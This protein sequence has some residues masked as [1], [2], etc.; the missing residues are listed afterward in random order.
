MS[1]ARDFD[2]SGGSPPA[3]PVSGISRMET[4]DPEGSFF[5]FH[6]AMKE[7]SIY[8]VYTANNDN[9]PRENRVK[10]AAQVLLGSF[11]I[12]VH[13]KEQP[14]LPLIATYYTHVADKLL[15]W[16]RS[17]DQLSIALDILDDELEDME[18]IT[19]IKPAKDAYAARKVTNKNC[20]IMK[21]VTLAMQ[22]WVVDQMG[23][24]ARDAI[25]T[26]HMEDCVAK[27]SP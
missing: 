27:A 4:K 26:S 24:E 17:D 25:I 5:D 19:P 9:L 16:Q 11:I 10:I 2:V 20:T 21:T 22:L 3:K 7:A 23:H 1:T 15:L 8:A 12:A 13:A 14:E 6:D 18:A